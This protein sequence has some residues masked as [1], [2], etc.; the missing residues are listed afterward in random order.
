MDFEA[1]RCKQGLPKNRAVDW[2]PKLAHLGAK[3]T[4]LQCAVNSVLKKYNGLLRNR[5][6]NPDALRS[7]LAEEFAKKNDTTSC[8]YIAIIK[9]IFIFCG[10]FTAP[11]FCFFCGTHTVTS[12]I[13]VCSYTATPNSDFSLYTASVTKSTSFSCDIFS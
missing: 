5:S 11:T 10:H 9:F 7:F 4:G 13:A 12:I 2:L 3:L 6:R 1:Y 8:L